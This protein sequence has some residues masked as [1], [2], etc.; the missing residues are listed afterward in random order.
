MRR[1]APLPQVEPL[2]N[3]ISP[4]SVAH[5]TLILG[6]GTSVLN[7]LTFADS[8]TNAKTHQ[9]LEFY[10]AADPSL[11]AANLAIAE[12]VGQS[13]EIY[14][15]RMTAGEILEIPT[16][17]GY[18]QLVN[19]SAGNVVAFFTDPGSTSFPAH[20]TDAV[21]STYFTGL[22]LGNKVSVS[23]G[24]SINGDVVTNYNDATGT[25]GGA[26]ET[27]GSATTLLA[28][29]V[30]NLTISGGINGTF[31][32]GGAVSHFSANG[33]VNQILTG[34]AGVNQTFSFANNNDGIL[35]GDTTLSQG[36]VLVAPKVAGPSL[37][38]VVVGSTN[39]IELGD[40]GLKAAGGSIHGLTLLNDTTGF[41]VQA[42]DGGMGGA[43]GSV[44]SVV[45][46]G[47]QSTSP[48]T[49][50]N[51]IIN[52]D[53][54]AGGPGIG[55]GKAGAGG[56]VQGVYVDY[57]SA[58]LSQPS[59][60]LILDDVSVIGGA[61]GSGNIG[62][63]GGS[64]SN[65]NVLTATPHLAGSTT[66]EYSLIGGAGGTGAGKG[67]IGG[68][69][70]NSQ[71]INQALPLVDPATGLPDDGSAI[72]PTATLGL[73]MGGLGGPATAKGAGGAGG[74]ISA[75]TL[76]GFNYDV[77]SG[78]GGAGVS[79][80]GAGGKIST[81]DVLGSSGNLPGDDFHVGSL[82]VSTGAGGNGSNGKGGAGG[83]IS[84][85]TVE[86]SD[87]GSTHLDLS[88]GTIQPFG[89]IVST[90]NGGT[91]GKG[92]GGAGGSI[93]SVRITNL[94]FL[95]ATHPQGDTAEISITAGNGGNA[96]VAGGK[97]GAGGSESNVVYV[98][99]RVAI[100]QVTAGQGG[101][102]GAIGVTGKGGAGGSLSS[103]SVSG[104]EELY[105][106]GLTAVTSTPGELVDSTANF[107]GDQVMVGDTVDNVTTG[108][109]ATVT[110]VVSSTELI[111]SNN[112]IAAND[113]Y[114]VTV[115][116]PF[117]NGS[118]SVYTGTAQDPNPGNDVLV[119]SYVN[120]YSAGVVPGDTIED[121]TAT[122]ANGGTP[123]TTTVTSVNSATPN[124][125]LV[126]QDI[127][128]AGDQIAFLSIG[129]G[130]PNAATYSNTTIIDPVS[131]F[132]T[133]NIQA[134]DVIEDLTQ[135]SIQGLPVTAT[136]ASVS[137]H[138]LS[139]T[140]QPGSLWQQ[141]SVLGD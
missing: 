77:F 54:G 14:F 88:T 26:S 137:A 96:E 129:T 62:G 127:Y 55:S 113:S 86:N 8:V 103:I 44:S 141:Y 31:Y 11:S 36:A 72:S 32:A 9:V 110:S 126:Q 133:E 123:V 10:N 138:S 92:A 65:I 35:H 132:S 27:P 15:I 17:V 48:D 90:G 3:R 12:T 99:T 136:V 4:A 46:N 115:P 114:A 68:S 93:S 18:Q 7:P 119:S 84:G 13:P 70:L 108:N 39:L 118:P 61:G 112:I 71:I 124:Q 5:G 117:L 80:G 91:A 69:V 120:F 139:L 22:A 85:L 33:E 101:Q 109:A 40:G 76:T 19:V 38:N 57:G 94:D 42:G 116:S 25:L 130:T 41:T 122:I 83:S 100:S 16:P 1:P 66:A 52:I 97:G 29:I 6:F 30:T 102:G 74:A 95:T 24:D 2:E 125:I 51:S 45:L 111:L 140:V 134:G 105:V 60:T 56:S 106:T 73:I 87:F 89:L 58:S 81:V 47:P 75:L 131:N 53:G 28:N 23:I 128:H 78:G 37:Y 20:A 63:A 79:A 64:L 107:T 135:T 98:G 121:I 67:G 59:N 50:P 49:T 43:G 82:V 34:T 21:D 104:G